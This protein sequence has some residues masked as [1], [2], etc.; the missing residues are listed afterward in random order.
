MNPAEDATAP[1]TQPPNSVDQTSSAT[2]PILPK[3]P[4]NPTEVPTAQPSNSIGLFE[5]QPIPPTSS[6]EKASAQPPP[7]VYL[8]QEFP[9]SYDLL[10]VDI[11][12]KPCETIDTWF[13]GGYHKNTDS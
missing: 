13:S 11:D 2:E 10:K 3:Q 5:I 6:A 12:T 4:S 7:H 8:T 1:T 9:D